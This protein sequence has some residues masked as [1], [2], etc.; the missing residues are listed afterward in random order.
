MCIQIVLPRRDFIV[1]RIHSTLRSFSLFGV[2]LE[3][4]V[5]VKFTQRIEN[6]L[7]YFKVGPGMRNVCLRTCKNRDGFMAHPDHINSFKG[8]MEIFELLWV[9][10]QWCFSL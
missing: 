9:I 6:L 5:L 4:P 7:P 8:G 2:V 1:Q 3:K 10:A